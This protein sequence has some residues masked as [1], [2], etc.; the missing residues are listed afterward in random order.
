MPASCGRVIATI[1][2]VL[3]AMVLATI[4]VAQE[5]QTAPTASVAGGN[6]RGLALSGQPGAVFR[7]I[8]FAQ[9]PV[10]DL[11]WREPQPVKAWTGVRAAEKP[12]APCA[13]AAAGWNDSFA[14]AGQEDCLYLDVWTPEW[15]VRSRK[16]VM[17]WIH[18]G[19]N[20]GGA[21]GF[22]P[23]YQGE[24][25]IRHDV[26]LVIPQYRL[27]I[28][29]FLAHPELTKESA[30]HASGNYGTLDLI[31]ALRWVHDN[32]EKFGGDPN[33][34]TI[35]GQS[36]GAFNASSLMA[37]PLA[38]GL[39]HKVI[40]Q[41]GFMAA[42]GGATLAQAEGEGLEAAKQFGASETGAIEQMRA[43]TAKELLNGPRVSRV[44][45][46]G[47]VF[48]TDMRDVF[49]S[50]KE[51]TVP[52]LLGNVT[53]EDMSSAGDLRKAMERDY[54]PLASKAIALYGLD[55][56]GGDARI[57]EQ[58]GTDTNFRC[59]GV[60]GAKWHSATGNP[61]WR[62]EFG[63]AIPP[64][65]N[66]SHSTDLPYVFGNLFSHGSQAGEFTV[67][68]RKLSDS[69]QTYWTNFAKRGDPN[70]DGVSVWP[71]FD[72]SK[73]QHVE[74]TATGAVE[75]ILDQRT[76]FCD[77]FGAVVKSAMGK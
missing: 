65:A 27:G 8:P 35:F 32:I 40:A 55:G 1:R 58:W 39:F 22:D 29:G 5:T 48:P 49:A 9:P 72:A 52:L 57:K 61:V 24:H 36:A 23:L 37:S 7:G 54:G 10:G 33:N 34:V 45:V 19:G 46:D 73:P 4:V 67:I 18:G 59:P 64:R 38:K 41:S 3:A 30:H 56:N 13:Q 77:L 31:A 44:N 51:A 28:L 60:L 76:A 12:G 25:L 16:P 70:G 20:M 53:V 69:V 6:I 62:Y 71:K 66:T 50:G 74:F 47:Y 43:M 11:R 75:A 21:G 42:L 68:D 26:V 2:V 63:R 17:F 15:P 14:A